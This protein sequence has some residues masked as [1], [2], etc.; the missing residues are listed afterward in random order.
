MTKTALETFAKLNAEREDDMEEIVKAH[1]EEEV[2]SFVAQVV[3]LRR[4]FLIFAHALC[5]LLCGRG[6]SHNCQLSVEV[7]W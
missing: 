4:T 5:V 7:T 6:M 2:C 3:C 1:K